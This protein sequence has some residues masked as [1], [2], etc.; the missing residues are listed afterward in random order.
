MNWLN[1]IN[2]SKP[3]W[4][5]KYNEYTIIE[6][7]FRV[8]VFAEDRY[9][10]PCGTQISQL[11]DYDLISVCIYENQESTINGKMLYQIINPSNNTIFEKEEYS[12]KQY[13]KS[14]SPNIMVSPQILCEILED[15]NNLNEMFKK[16]NVLK[17]K[18]VN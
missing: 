6:G 12:W 7:H 2:N 13:Y 5:G 18:E 15:I 9:S 11:Q 4:N 16:V 1:I 8:C 17:T 14:N 10:I 3:T